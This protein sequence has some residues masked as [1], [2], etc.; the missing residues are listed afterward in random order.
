MKLFNLING[1]E[2]HIAPGQS[3]VPSEIFSQLMDAK[4]LIDTVKK[5]AEEYKKQVLAESEKQKE[6]AF[7]EGFIEGLEKWSQQIAYMEDEIKKV[8]RDVE[9]VA[10][11]LALKTAK[12]IIGREIELDPSTVSD[13]VANQLKAV[14]E[15]KKIIVYVNKHDL[16]VLEKDKKR[17]ESIFS[18]LES[19]SIQIN[20][21]VQPNGCI[22][23]TEQG[24]INAQIEN[25]WKILERVFENMLQEIDAPKENVGA[26]VA[27]EPTQENA[28]G[29]P[30]VEKDPV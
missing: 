7:K 4:E 8:Y 2:I 30:E 27:K 19:L 26:D 12:K 11:P 9:K 25:Q 13:I 23:E 21:D 20:Q 5:D 15:H 14:S 1:N 29:E 10:V 28:S 6:Q 18:K 16:E 24:I 22:I 3:I 17:F